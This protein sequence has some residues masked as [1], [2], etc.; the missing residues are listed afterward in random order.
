MV[1]FKKI[2]DAVLE[3]EGGYSNDP[4][5]YGGETYMGISRVHFPLW[6]GWVIIDAYSRSRKTLPDLRVQLKKDGDLTMAVRSFYRDHFWNRFQGDTIPDYGIA[7]ELMD[8]AVNMGVH[9]AVLILQKA[10][11]V[12]NRNE[13]TYSDIVED[14][15][16]GPMTLAALRQFLSIDS[17]ALLCKVMNIMQGARYLEIMKKSTSQERFARGWLKRVSIVDKRDL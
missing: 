11:N 5:D 12:L 8:I 6:P 17:P 3:H 4:V 1:E 7:L 9:R 14:G 16:L 2:L 13:L 15:G 10:L